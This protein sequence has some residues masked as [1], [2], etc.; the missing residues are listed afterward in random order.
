MWTEYARQTRWG[1]HPEAVDEEQVPPG[2]IYVKQVI[3]LPCS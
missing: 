2:S 1:H 3:W